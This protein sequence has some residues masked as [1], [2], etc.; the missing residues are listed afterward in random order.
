MLAIDANDQNGFNNLGITYRDAGKFYGE[1]G[2]FAK[3]EKYLNKA[4]EMRGEE[5]EIL[6][7][8]GVLNGTRGNHPIAIQYFQKAVNK[9]P[10]N[11]Q[12]LFNLSAAYQYGGDLEN[13][14]KYLQQARAIDPKIG[15]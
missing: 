9:E 5:Y 7:L 8:L 4:L 12:A 14:Q 2:D 11:A 1:K 3:A 10:K 13:A 15:Q 6:R